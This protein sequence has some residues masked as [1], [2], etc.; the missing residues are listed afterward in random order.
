M[1]KSAKKK[2]KKIVKLPARTLVNLRKANCK[3]DPRV[4]ERIRIKNPPRRS[5]LSLVKR[6]VTKKWRERLDDDGQHRRSAIETASARYRRCIKPPIRPGV[7]KKKKVAAALQEG[8]KRRRRMP[9]PEAL[10]PTNYA[11]MLNLI[12]LRYRQKP[13]GP[14]EHV[15]YL[16][17]SPKAATEWE[18]GI[19]VKISRHIDSNW[20][21]VRKNP[22]PEDVCANPYLAIDSTNVFVA[23]PDDVDCGLFLNSGVYVLF[24]RC[25]NTFYIG[26][27]HKI[28]ARIVSHQAGTGSQGTRGFVSSFRLQPR[29]MRGGTWRQWER[30]EWLMLTKLYPNS[31]VVGAGSSQTR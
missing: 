23:P 14:D 31:T 3:L 8:S 20:V 6:Q 24:A 1:V 28:A 27:S 22:A 9:T 4:N 15:I 18:R 5:K 30:R 21:L 17:H 19:V 29:S 11:E 10:R 25:C 26:E 2:A 13:V 7:K 12:P 16:K